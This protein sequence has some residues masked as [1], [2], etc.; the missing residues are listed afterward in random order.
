[1]T[2]GFP[3][4]GFIKTREDP[5][6]L[7]KRK[8]GKMVQAYNKYHHIMSRGGYELIEEK[9][10][11]EKIKQRQE[12]A[13]EA[14]PTPPSPPKR[15]E[16]WL[17]GR[18]RPSGEFTSEETRLV[19]DNINSLVQKTSEGTFVP[20]GRHDILREAIGRPEHPG[21]IKISFLLLIQL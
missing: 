7:E 15:H 19:A 1:M 16:K 12:S 13:G 5:S 14:L 20:Q 9:M 6:F 4:R 2:N 11:Q 21:R 10:M 18:K 3:M 17:R 8:R